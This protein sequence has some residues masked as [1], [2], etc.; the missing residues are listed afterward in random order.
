M[1]IAV[2]VIF[3]NALIAMADPAASCND[4]V[5]TYAEPREPARAILVVAYTNSQFSVTDASGKKTI[6]EVKQ[7]EEGLVFVED[8]RDRNVFRLSASAKP[9]VF[10][11]EYLGKHKQG[12]PLPEGPGEKRE[13][14]RI[15]RTQSITETK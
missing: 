2:A 4:L 13:L 7:T 8:P 6:V 15:Q 12:S 10:V 1:G 11:F 9:G 3:A 14:V 5:G